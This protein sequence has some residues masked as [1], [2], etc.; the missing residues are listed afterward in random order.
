M[1]IT[2]EG[3]S[4]TQSILNRVTYIVLSLFLALMI[5]ASISQKAMARPAFSAITV[6]AA[7]GKILY[8]KD[9]D[10][11]RYPASLTKVMTLY[12]LFQE[13]DAGRMS[14]STKMK[15]SKKASRQQPSKLGLRAG[16]SISARDAMYALITKSA[17][18]AAMVIAEHISGSQDAF[19]NRMTKTARSIGMTRTTFKNPNGLPDS[20]QTTTARDMATLGLRIQHDFP[21]YYKFFATRS[22]KYGKRRYSNHN[23]L[24]GRLK[25]VDGIKTGYTRASGFNLISSRKLNGRRI[26][27]V[28]MG[29]RS[30]RSRNAYMTKI[31]RRDIAKATRGGNRIAAV[32]GKPA[33]YRAPAPKVIIA[34]AQKA[35]PSIAKAPIPRAKPAIETAPA[36]E[37]QQIAAIAKSVSVGPVPATKPAAAAKVK[38]PTITQ[39][40]LAAMPAVGVTFASVVVPSSTS[41][42]DSLIV[43]HAAQAL[44][45][46][47]PEP[48]KDQARLTNPQPIA[49]VASVEGTTVIH[50][51][52]KVEEKLAKHQSSWNIQIGAFPTQAGAKS[53]IDDAN[54]SK[55]R[56]LRKAT[57][58][59][60]A[61]DKD[62]DTIYRAR[63]SGLNRKQARSACR[64]LKRAGVGCFPLAPSS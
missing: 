41:K 60:M 38:Q 47:A 14:F 2:S 42:S 17:N 56:S 28:V 53:R 4:S 43:A 21:R 19:A 55:L 40:A 51:R 46:P 45:A 57:P 44:A 52:A 20:R 63:F 33:G 31:L 23:R 11:K 29:G 10:S 61:V 13:I 54:A 62:G 32:A 7:T 64:Q 22:F 5:A 15:V 59:L 35:K 3:Y 58:F 48:E 6:D 39:E 8:G 16:I 49:E 50:D 1:G 34:S 12:L 18:D 25:G 36:P 37:Q 26:V 30:G 27:G 24:L 9:I